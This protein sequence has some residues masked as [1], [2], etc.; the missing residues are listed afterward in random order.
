MKPTSNEK[1]RTTRVA[2]YGI[3]ERHGEL[4]LCRCATSV[5]DAGFWTLPGG[6][7]EFG[8]DP[9]EAMIREVREET[10]LNVEPNGIAGV[11]SDL[12]E[13]GDRFLHS[14]RV[15]YFATVVDGTLQNET[16]GSTDMCQWHTISTLQ[17]LPLLDLVQWA[18]S[19]L[20]NSKDR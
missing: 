18:L 4:L 12:D 19:D 2:A 1:P 20:R 14:I 16:D 3:I 5:S 11:K 15:A 10:G 8:E 7:I 6:G 13:E 17:Q 9:E